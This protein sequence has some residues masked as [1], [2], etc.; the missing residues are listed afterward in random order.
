MAPL[1][2]HSLLAT[3]QQGQGVEAMTESLEQPVN[4]RK[5]AV[6]ETTSVT[7]LNFTPEYR[8]YI[9]LGTVAGKSP[10]LH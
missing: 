7:L 6:Q 4:M 9:G 8:E 3:S 10:N 2:L 1:Y 5:T